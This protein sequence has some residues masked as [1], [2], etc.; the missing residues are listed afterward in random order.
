MDDLTATVP[1]DGGSPRPGPS[2]EALGRGVTVGRYVVL[3]HI[4]AGGMGVVYAAYDPELDRRVA[5][6]LLRPDR[7]SSDAGRLRLL[8]EAQALA[9]LTHPNVVAV[10]DAGTFGDRVFV[11]MELVEGE[12]LRQWLRAEPRSPRAWREVL[13]RFLPAGRGLAAA[14]AAGLVHRD[15]K[16]ENVLLGRD[17]RARVVDFGL[18]KALADAA[19]EP[20]AA[21]APAEEPGGALVTPL[22]EWGVVLGT[23]AYMAPE[24]LRG[25]AADARSDQ[26]SYCVALYEALYGER[27]FPGANPREVA[28]EVLRGAIREA[29][30]ETKVP[31]WLRAVVLRGLKVDPEARYPT[32]DDLLHDLS[33][34]PEAVRRRWL[35][36]A[37]VVVLVGAIFGGLGY[38]Q[39]RRAQLCG[40]GEEQLAGV[41]DAGRKRAIHAAFLATGRP[42]AETVWRSVERELDGYLGDWVESRRRACEA[43]RVRG[44]QSEELLDRK[45]SCLDQRLGEAGALTD[46]LTR[47]D[48]RIV[49]KA[50]DAARALG[51]L[52]ACSRNGI[53]LEKAPLPRDPALRARIA[54]AQTGLAGAKALHRAGKYRDALARAEALRGTVMA[55]P[56]RP[57]QAETLFLL[58]RLHLALGDYPRSEEELYEAAGAAEEGRDDPLKTEAWRELVSNVGTH[59]ARY[60]EARRLARQAEAA[61]ARSGGDPKAEASLLNTEAGFLSAQDDYPQAVRKLERA[62]ALAERIDARNPGYGILANLGGTY[63]DMGAPERAIPVL[64]RALELAERTVGADHPST[65]RIGFNLGL[66]LSDLGRYGEADVLLRRTL[67]AYER[68]LGR[69]HPDVG[70]ILVQIGSNWTRTGQPGPALP[71]LRRALAIFDAKAP[72]TPSQWAIA[73]AEL[74]NAEHALGQDAEALAHE[75]EAIRCIE[76]KAGPESDSLLT[77]LEILGSIYLEQGRPGLAVPPLE[78]A[79]RLYDQPR[80]ELPR[81]NAEVRF[82]LA[83]ALWRAGRERPRAVLLARQAR[84]IY[85]QVPASARTEMAPL[86]AWLAAHGG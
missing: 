66:C 55:L 35:T 17:G 68:L 15:F 64:Q 60:G 59:Q 85:G 13:E 5:L 14:H 33:R 79:V 38:F 57:L 69:D 9:R 34:D 76:T 26:F 62:R 18:A 12:T 47:A 80:P 37:V 71:V 29:P 19:E 6:K 39:A 44:D 7:F 23:P 8:R 28:E 61:L 54:A 84:E 20:E 52:S 32:M 3:D 24:Q 51:D 75:R 16:P 11:A 1:L 72:Q 83:Q 67:A 77:P 21:G 63:R 73:Q 45:T 70:N 78:R 27:P 36:A 86:N 49:E 2:A 82:L 43:T 31:G 40:G 10:Y 56:F 41:W 22:T 4:G 58:G 53:L 81:W 42:F 48:A 50:H 74:G 25:V 65:L 46:L 30:A